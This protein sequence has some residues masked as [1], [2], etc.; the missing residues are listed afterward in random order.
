MADSFLT[1]ADLVKVNDQNLADIEVSDLLDDAPLL[2]ALAADFASNG[3]DHKYL[4]E[5]GAP[6]VGFRAPNTGRENTKSADTL[7]TINLKILDA[8]TTV[9]KALAD[10]YQRGGPEAYVGREARRHLRA[11]FFHAEKQFINGTGNEADGFTGM[12]DA[13]TV[14][15][16]A[17]AMVI[18]AGGTTINTASSVWLIRTND[19]GTDVS[20]ITGREGQI[21]IGDTIVQ[22]I[23]DTV[24]GGRFSAYYTPI[25]G[26]LGLQ[27]GSAFSI[28]RIVNLTEDAGKGLTDDLI[29]QALA[30]FPASRQPNVIAM[31]RRSLRQLR[32]SRTATNVTGA[33]AP[34]PTDVDG[35]PILSTD[36]IVNTEA[37]VA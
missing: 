37:L 21:M 6:V 9:D 17:D 23:Q 30:A 4:K 20:A 25:E 27:V 34:R 19:M 8:S 28:A 2:A 15:G 24:N 3:T 35:I 31:S 32:E 11:A 12:A 5:T 10:A 18:D 1:L 16:L 29:Y 26:W 7:V 13:A 36:A 33:P 14:D 22:A